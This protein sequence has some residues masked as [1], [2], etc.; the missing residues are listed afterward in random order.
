VEDSEEARS[1][2][3][4]AIGRLFTLD[5]LVALIFQLEE[6][7]KDD[8]RFTRCIGAEEDGKP[9]KVTGD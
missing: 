2:E 9:E 4:Q 6:K 5:E 1:V 8:E 7:V 3:G